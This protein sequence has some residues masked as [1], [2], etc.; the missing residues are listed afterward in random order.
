M[1]LVISTNSFNGKTHILSSKSEIH[2]LLM[3]A[4]L[5]KG[6]RETEISFVGKPSKDVIATK[7]CMNIGGASIVEN[8]N[9]FYCMPINNRPLYPICVNCNESGSTLRFLL[10]IFSALGKKYTVLVNGSLSTRPLSPMYELLQSNG[11]TLSENGKY[12]LSISGEFLGGDLTIDGSVSSQFISGILMALPL[13][14]NGGSLTIT[15]DF[16]S[17]PYVDITVGIMRDFGVEVMEENNT[18]YVKKADYIS[19]ICVNAGGDWSNAA[20]FLVGGA[21]GGKVTVS[22]LD[23]NSNQ[24]DKQMIEILKKFGANIECNNDQIT[25]SKSTLYATDIDVKNIPDLV[26]IIAVLA[27]VSKGTTKIYNAQRLRIKESNRIKSTIDMI[28]SL[29]GVAIETEDGMIIQGKSEL[30]GGEV[31]SYNDHRIA[32]SASIAS[33]VCKNSVTIK[34]AQAVDKSFPE[35]YEKIKELG[36]NVKEI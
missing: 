11:V 2:R 6:D 28:N 19:P 3:I 35:F 17:K 36:S 29:G 16:Q 23:L 27:S 9:V 14:K 31:F 13:T 18:Y 34:E 33:V 30:Q 5:C 15:G 20:F 12:P 32:M 24:G 8:N 1:N 25:V 21:I 22:G 4:S 7:E 26:P 10:P